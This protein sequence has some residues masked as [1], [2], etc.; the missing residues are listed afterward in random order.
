MSF[1]RIIFFLCTVILA[2]GWY[3]CANIVPPEGGKK[4]ETAPVLLSVSPVDSS[5]NAR[6]SR[7]VLH[8]NEYMEVQELDKQMQ[9]SPLLPMAPTVLSYGK[10][11][12]IKLQDTQLQPNTT[13]MIS[14]GDAL[15]DN[16]EGNPYK[17]FVYTFSTGSYFDSLTLQ[18][19]VLNAETGLTDTSVLVALYAATESDTAVLRQKPMYAVRADASGKFGFKALPRKAFR[20]YAV[21]DA[22]NNFIYDFGAEKIGFLNTA[23]IPSADKDTSYTF[24]IFREFADTSSISAEDTARATD[25]R[26]NQADSV[27]G[28]FA[29]RSG[30]N[31]S[32]KSRNSQG[33][34]VHV[35]TSDLS[36]RTFELTQPLT[37]RIFE[38]LQFLDTAKV[39]LSYENNGIEVEGIRQLQSDS[40]GLSI[41]SQWQPDKLYTLRLVK[42]W[43]RDTAG[44]E[45]LPGKYRFHTKREED[46][47]T[48]KIHLPGA[49]YND[50]FLLYVFK[51]TDSIYLR[52]VTDSVVT[53]SL[54]Q[55]GDYGM[56]LIA[57]GNRNG[58]WDPGNLLKKI[59]PEL[60][61]PYKDKL[62]LKAGWENEIDFVPADNSKKTGTKKFED[63]MKEDGKKEQEKE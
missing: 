20:M 51:G 13:Y 38:E 5:L 25:A 32:R 59:Q 34:Q 21:Q 48:L 47:G 12:E 27:K 28:T 22:N 6:P 23:V 35:D 52:P 46:Y 63:R 45:L 40:A 31:T 10:R 15:R 37:I 1:S 50:S 16:H 29:G 60:S 2:A 3:G 58:K 4:D 55:P 41:R 42:G 17:G 8:F 44:N 18:G 30:K 26:S 9:L 33:Y 49:F 7:I 14:L 61:I 57:D 54:L 36:K 39:Y 19:Q 56:R 24:R 11:V 53:I 43:A 62:V